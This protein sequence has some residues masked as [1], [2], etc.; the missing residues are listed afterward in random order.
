MEMILRTRKLGLDKLV[1]RHI[2]RKLFLD[3]Y[4]NIFGAKLILIFMFWKSREDL[5]DF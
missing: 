5:C 2:S 4:R 1:D 3:I